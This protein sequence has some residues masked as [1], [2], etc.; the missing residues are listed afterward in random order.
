DPL[1]DYGYGFSMPH[2][3]FGATLLEHGGSL[4]AVSAKFGIIP[5][6]ELSV[7][8]LTNTSGFAATRVLRMLLNVYGGRS[9]DAEAIVFDDYHVDAM[10]AKSYA[11]RYMSGEGMDVTLEAKEDG[12]LTFAYKGDVYPIQFIR[13]HVF[14]AYMDDA[15]E[16]CEIIV[17][18]KDKPTGV[19][20]FHRILPK[21]EE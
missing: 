6:E 10:V 2:D 9:L 14:V 20:I 4:Q 5:E 12:S 18:E 16:A 3:F 19:S 15:I 1:N 7:I 21:V 13:E 8:V 17:D 11:G